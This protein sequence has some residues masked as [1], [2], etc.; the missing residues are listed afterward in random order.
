MADNKPPAGA[1]FVAKIVKDPKNPPATLMLTGFLG[2]SSEDGHTRLYFDPNLSSYVEIPNDAIL[3]T[4]ES[5]SDD[6]LGAAHVWITRDAQLTFGAAAPQR[7]KGTFLDGPIMQDHLAGTAAAAAAGVAFPITVAVCAPTQSPVQCRPTLVVCAPS[8][9]H[10][11][12]TLPS[13]APLC[14]TAGVP[15]MV[16]V[17]HPC[18]TPRTQFCLTQLICQNEVQGGF[19]GPAEMQRA[20]AFAAIPTIS[21]LGHVCASHTPGCGGGGGTLQMAAVT[22][23][24]GC[25]QVCHPSFLGMGCGTG[26]GTLAV[27]VSQNC[28][29]HN[30]LC[31]HHTGLACTV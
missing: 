26:G 31:P 15:C 13:L 24:S 20:A 10:P 6:G 1:D 8:V 21:P 18:P 30:P 3:H 23:W 25:S 16:S 4:Q 14:H 7:A 11:C 5:A 9:Q 12:Y 29:G 22:L 27:A 2:A 19:G 17:M 28:T